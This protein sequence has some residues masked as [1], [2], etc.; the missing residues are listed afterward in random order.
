MAVSV[1]NLQVVRVS[2]PCSSLPMSEFGLARLLKPWR[3]APY[4]VQSRTACVA[5]SIWTRLMW[6]LIESIACIRIV[7]ARR[8][9]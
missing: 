2:H 1:L 7:M 5:L 8:L 4:M 6:I 9:S 3:S